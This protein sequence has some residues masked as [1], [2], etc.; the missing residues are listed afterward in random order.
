MRKEGSHLLYTIF[1]NKN[2]LV[3]TILSSFTENVNLFMT[4]SSLELV[5]YLTY[6]PQCGGLR[7]SKAHI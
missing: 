1:S 7:K 4:L 5:V 2:P 3:E 6:F